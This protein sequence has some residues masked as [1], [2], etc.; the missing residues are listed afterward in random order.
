M[1]NTAEVI[2]GHVSKHIL[3]DDGFFPNNPNY[4]LLVYKRAIH[5]HPGDEAEIIL[6]TFKNNNWTNGWIDTI[7]DYDHYHS[8]THEVLA[9]FCGIADVYL[10]GPQGVTLELARGDVLIIPAGVAHKRINSSHDFLCVGAYPEGR[11]YDMNY[12]TKEERSKTIENIK[13]VPIPKLDPVFGNQG[14]LLEFWNDST[15]E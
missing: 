4:P 9:I 8:T 6:K 7:Y 5:L 10:G 3:E 15:S 11:N 13:N 2:H 1:N 12:G 14:G